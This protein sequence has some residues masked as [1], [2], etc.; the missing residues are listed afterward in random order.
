M[1]LHHRSRAPSVAPAPGRRWPFGLSPP[2]ALVTACSTA[3]LAAGVVLALGKGALPAPRIVHAEVIGVARAQRAR[4]TLQIRGTQARLEFARLP[5]PRAGHLNEVF[6]QRGA[7]APA[8]AGTF[9]RRSGS[10]IVAAPVRRGDRVLVTVEPR[11]GSPVPTTA[12]LIVA[13][14]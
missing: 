12:P 4:A 10:V 9:A 8:P 7:A 13:R 14:V 2:V 5:V 1:S 6:V 11:P 3:V